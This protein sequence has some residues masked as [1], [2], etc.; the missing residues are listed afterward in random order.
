MPLE[1][2]SAMINFFFVNSVIQL[3]SFFCVNVLFSSRKWTI[4]VQQQSFSTQ[5]TCVVSGNPNNK[6]LKHL[7]LCRMTI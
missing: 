1:A 6:P 4:S 5:S 7:Y 2:Q 3:L